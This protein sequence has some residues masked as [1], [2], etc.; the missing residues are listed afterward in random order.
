[1]TEDE[2]DLDA[3]DHALLMH[4]GW[5]KDDIGTA[6]VVPSP[7]RSL[8]EALPLMVKYRMTL[9][10]PGC[11]F[12]HGVEQGWSAEANEA[13]AAKVRWELLSPALAV[14]LCAAR[15]AGIDV[16]QFQKAKT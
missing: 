4:L 8:D 11:S 6:A 15:C 2:Y 7:T 1:M 16:G 10:A 9:Y 3:L 14:A 5:T 13:F 12:A